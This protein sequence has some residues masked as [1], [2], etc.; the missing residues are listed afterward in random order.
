MLNLTDLKNDYDR[1]DA[2]VS[3]LID[4]ST[5]GPSD[6]DGYDAL[7]LYFIQ[8]TTLQTYLPVWYPPKR[9]LH[10]FWQ[11]IKHKFAHYHERRDFLWSEFDPLLKYCEG[12]A[13]HPAQK[14][15]TEGLTSF[16]KEN[17]NRSWERM[18][19]RSKNDPEGAITAARTLLESV[20]KH[21]LD[22]RKSE[23]ADAKIELPD[24]YKQV[25]TE[26]NLSPDQHT[27]GIFKQILGSCSGIV[28]GLGGL[29]NKLGDA[30]GKGSKH[31]RPLP[32]HAL[33]AVN[34]AGSMALFLIQTFTGKTD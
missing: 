29:R 16:D 18:V 33:L 28:N 4:A 23:Y 30:H 25:A 14:T 7:R 2:L 8:H 22:E 9:S 12:G 1:A 11:F 34:L 31:V 26:L 21:I 32:R 27:L 15:I 6:G 3:L 5:G 24:L 20:C 10:Q 19:E 13:S 17:I